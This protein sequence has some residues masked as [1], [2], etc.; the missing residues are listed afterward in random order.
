VIFGVL[1]IWAVYLL[2]KELFNRNVG[3]LSAFFIT[4]L[5][6]EILWSRQARPYQA[7]QFLFLLGAYFLYKLVKNKKFDRNY[8]LGFLSTATLAS[9][10]HGLGVF[11][12]LFGFVYLLAIKFS[13]FKKRYFLSLVIILTVVVFSYFLKGKIISTLERFAEFNNLYYYRVFLTHHYLLLTFLALLGG[14]FLLLK[15]KLKEIILFVIFL[16]FQF[17]LV[18]WFLPQP[19]TRYFYIVFSFILLL[20]SYFLWFLSKF[21]K[22]KFL[23]LVLLLFL[24]FATVYLS[25]NKV[26]ILPQ[27]IY[28]LNEDMQEIPEVD[29]KKIYG[30]VGEKLKQDKDMVLITNWTDLPVW[31][32]GEG[33]LSYLLR[34]GDV[35][36]DGFTGAELINNLSKFRE[37]IAKEEKGI[38]IIDSWDNYVPDGIREYLCENLKKE[39]EID[40]LYEVQPRYWPVEVYS[41]GI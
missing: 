24:V 16:G 23:S 31:F 5:K 11:L 21:L 35:K 30:F 39:L 4:F 37:V 36:I 1:T 17:I 38:V 29:W 28:S 34:Q 3:L 10:M 13:W 2:G 7:L 18:S 25:K 9:L 33:E 27:R 26:A 22:N 8:F 12:F 14:L 32:L 19:F 15:K 20:S 6:I 40:R 41:W